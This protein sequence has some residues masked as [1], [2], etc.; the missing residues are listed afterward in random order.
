MRGIRL[1]VLTAFLP[2]R[3][4]R[5]WLE[6]VV[7]SWA[8]SWLLNVCDPMTIVGKI[9]PLFIFTASHKNIT[10]HIGFYFSTENMMLETKVLVN[11]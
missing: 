7:Q 6:D 11:K 10:M 1:D 3:I 8:V 2:R 5:R 9:G 4:V